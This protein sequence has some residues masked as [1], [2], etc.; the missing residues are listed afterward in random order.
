M[1]RSGFS[2]PEL[3]VGMAVTM[4]A[5]GALLAIFT[6]SVRIWK[7]TN[8]RSTAVEAL[9][10]AESRMVE[11]LVAT[12]ADSITVVNDQD[13]VAVSFLTAT[14]FDP[15]TGQPIWDG[16]TVYRLQDG[17]LERRRPT[18]P[19]LPATQPF[20]FTS[21]ELR[22]LCQTPDPDARLIARGITEIRLTGGATGVWELVLTAQARTD[23]GPEVH[24]RRLV[25][26]PRMS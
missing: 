8:A 22:L 24:Q 23:A 2:V 25:L 19:G 16:L 4:L 21:T 5:M 18:Q 10:F 14:G 15:A 12:T 13:L 9:V 17:R 1:R 20:A 11:D 7:L 26:Q 3:I 6:Q